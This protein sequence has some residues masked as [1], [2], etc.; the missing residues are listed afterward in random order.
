MYKLKHLLKV[1]TPSNSLAQ[2]IILLQH[3][4]GLLDHSF[5][6]FSSMGRMSMSGDKRAKKNQ[7]FDLKDALEA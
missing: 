5:L 1:T 3:S 7:G 2:R 6:R 4:R